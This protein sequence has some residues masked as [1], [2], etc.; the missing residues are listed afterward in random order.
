MRDAGLGRRGPTDSRRFQI[1]PD[2]KAVLPAEMQ[3]AQGSTFAVKTN[4]FP[5]LMEKQLPVYQYRVEVFGMQ[6]EEALGQVKMPLFR[7]FREE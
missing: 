3:P 1:D 6:K 5:L 4:A 2:Q 7:Q